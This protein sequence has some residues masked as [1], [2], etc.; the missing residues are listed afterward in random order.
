MLRSVAAAPLLGAAGSM[1]WL[2]HGD[3]RCL[4]VLELDGGN[5]G[6]NTIL[7]LEDPAWARARPQ[8]AGVRRGAH[9]LAGGFGLH[10]AMS[11]LH[12]LMRDGLAA[13][14]HGVGFAGSSRSHFHNR[15][16]WHTADPSFRELRADST[17]WLGRA[18]DLLATGGAA[19]PG[20]SVGSLS[21]PLVLKA[22]EVVVPG[23]RRIED[24][25]VLVSPGPDAARRREQLIALATGEG[26]G[27]KGSDGLRSFLCG[28][29]RTAADSSEALHTALA[30]YRPKARYPATALGRK[31]QL[32]ARIVICGFGTRLFH[33]NFSGFDTHAGQLATHEALLRQ[34]SEAVTALVRDLVAHRMA[35]RVLGMVPSEF[36][37]RVAENRS[38]G[39]DHGDAGPV[40]WFGGALRPGLHGAH[41]SLTS[42]RDGDL[43]PTTDFRGLYGAALG[44]LGLDAKPV[45]GDEFLLAPGVNP[46]RA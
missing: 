33:V 30:R 24:Y 7:P 35:D 43:V 15:D 26:E 28:V 16:V 39:T 3:S 4:V 44:F 32:L 37:R 25:R 2:P 8:L 10:P 21:V 18:A 40:L 22:K 11:G 45:L 36:G 6:L 9:R 34:L 46:V 31:L 29:A 42:L 27:R 19:V 1:R 20:L 12:G 41:P 38:G 5:D 13:V 17:G 14:V 23:L